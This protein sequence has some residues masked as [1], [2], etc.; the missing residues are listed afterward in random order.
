MSKH[1]LCFAEAVA[2]DVATRV[3][4]KLDIHP[5]GV[6]GAFV[7]KAVLRAFGCTCLIAPECPLH[8][9]GARDA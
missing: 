8:P 2:A 7:R 9:Q 3:T 1:L 4:S 5:G 6:D